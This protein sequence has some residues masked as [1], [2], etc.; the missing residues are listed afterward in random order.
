MVSRFTATARSMY[1]HYL[2]TRTPSGK[3]RD[4]L[5]KNES[6]LNFVRQVWH[7]PAREEGVMFGDFG[8][9]GSWFV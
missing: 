7:G 2:R 1:G 8:G 5:M 6:D 4:R 3:V 9:H